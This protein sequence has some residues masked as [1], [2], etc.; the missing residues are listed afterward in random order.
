MIKELSMPVYNL[1]RTLSSLNT[2][3]ATRDTFLQRSIHSLNDSQIENQ[4][5]VII[6]L[7]TMSVLVDFK[8]NNE[9]CHAC[10]RIESCASPCFSPLTK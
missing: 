7:K 8:V 5:M 6:D 1:K 3:I 10:V 4:K 9:H 2:E